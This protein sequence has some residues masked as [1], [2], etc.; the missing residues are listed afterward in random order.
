MYMM[1]SL[2]HNKA[3]CK[4]NVDIVNSALACATILVCHNAPNQPKITAMGIDP[5]LL[6][7][8]TYSDKTD[9]RLRRDNEKSE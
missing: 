3:Q 9:P 5:S 1:R 2:N 8:R 7:T 4:P 6:A